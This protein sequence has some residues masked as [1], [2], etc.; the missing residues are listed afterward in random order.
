MNFHA[1]KHEFRPKFID[2]RYGRLVESQLHGQLMVFS[3][4]NF[5]PNALGQ[6]M[7]ERQLQQNSIYLFI[8]LFSLSLQ[9]D[10]ISGSG[11]DDS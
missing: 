3:L 4:S 6:V 10:S 5:S 1:S 2:L 9:L 7:F 8:R 11:V